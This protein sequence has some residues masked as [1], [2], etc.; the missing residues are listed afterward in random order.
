MTTRCRMSATRFQLARASAHAWTV[1]AAMA[2]GF[3]TAKAK[4]WT[5]TGDPKVRRAIQSAQ[6]WAALAFALRDGHPMLA[7]VRA[8]GGGHE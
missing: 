3:V 4:A 8:K 7:A 5:L 1:D 2:M 6:G